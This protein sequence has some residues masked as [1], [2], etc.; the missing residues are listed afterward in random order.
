MTALTVLGIIVLFFVF[1][2][3]LPGAGIMP[4]TVD[5]RGLSA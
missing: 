5:P 2:L 1:L 3:S 4:E